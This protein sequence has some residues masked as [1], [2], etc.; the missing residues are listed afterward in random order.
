MDDLSEFA[1]FHD[2]YLMGISTDLKA[3]QVEL[4]LQFDDGKQRARALFKGASRC[5]VN[6]FLIQ[7]I[8]YEIT[9]LTD[10]ESIEYKQALDALEKSYFGKDNSAFKPIAVVTAT[11]G[12]D[13]LIE[14][15]TLDVAPEI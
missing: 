6:D 9:V 8:V 4:S 11:L 1:S 5:L 7:N 14:F 10:Y 15:E 12:A 2:W 3:K 13:L